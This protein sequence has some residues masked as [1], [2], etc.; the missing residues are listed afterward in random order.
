MVSAMREERFVLEQL[1]VRVHAYGRIEPGITDSLREIGILDLPSYCERKNT[2]VEEVLGRLGYLS[3]QIGFLLLQLNAPKILVGYDKTPAVLGFLEPTFTATFLGTKI[4]RRKENFL[5][6]TKILTHR[7]FV[8]QIII[9][10]KLGSKVVLIPLHLD[11]LT[12]SYEIKLR[13]LGTEIC[14][15]SI[16][17]YP[18]QIPKNVLGVDDY[19]KLLV[20]YAS[21]LD[22]LIFGLE[23]R[24]ADFSRD[25]TN[26]EKVSTPI[27]SSIEAFGIHILNEESFVRFFIDA[28]LE[29]KAIRSTLKRTINN[30]QS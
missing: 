13:G 26:E 22:A 5:Y 14:Y 1:T 3:P 20:R 24:I 30:I 16:D 7:N 2:S 10:A 11:D 19:R 9:S 15:I 6:G 27:E 29:L 8:N 18:I 28:Y 17:E 23:K 12:T 21:M 25:F 4:K